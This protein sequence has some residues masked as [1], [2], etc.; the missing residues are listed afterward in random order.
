MELKVIELQL[1]EFA[2]KKKGKNKFVVLYGI[3]KEYG[4]FT[5]NE[6]KESEIKLSN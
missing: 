6:I 3:W 5:Y 1:K 4:D 2:L